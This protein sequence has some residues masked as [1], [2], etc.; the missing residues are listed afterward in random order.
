MSTYPK[1]VR[2]QLK[3]ITIQEFQSALVKDGWEL[4]RSEGARVTYVKNDK[5]ITLHIHPKKKPWVQICLNIYLNKQDGTLETLK[6]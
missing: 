4:V 3:N 1:Q 5:V 2:D 6:E